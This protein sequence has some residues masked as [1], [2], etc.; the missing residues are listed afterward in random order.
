MI[1]YQYINIV[2]ITKEKGRQIKVKKIFSQIYALKGMILKM[3]NEKA[4]TLIALVITIIVLLIL[5]AISVVALIGDNG[6]LSNSR[7]AKEEHQIS[8]Y[9]EE[10]NLVITEEITERKIEAKQELM[11]KSLDTKIRK[12]EWVNEIYKLDNNKQEQQTFETST[13]LLVESKE[14]YEF[15]IEVNDLKNTAKIISEGKGTG[16]KYKITFNPNG[17]LGTENSQE[18]KQKLSVTLGECTFTKENY[19]F[20]GW[21]E[22]S[23]GTGERYLPQAL[24][25]PSQDVTLYAIWELNVATITFNNN[26]GTGNM[27]SVTVEKEKDS[28]LPVNTF[29]R[30]DYKFIEWNTKPDGTGEKYADKANIN[31]STDIIL[32]AIWQE[33]PFEPETLSIGSA[34]NANKYGWKVTNYEPNIGTVG[35]WRLFYQDE[36]FT[37]IISDNVLSHNINS[38][39][40]KYQSAADISMIGRKLN[41]TLSAYSG[42]Y[43]S[44]RTDISLR[45]AAVLSDPTRTN[46]QNNINEDALFSILSPSIDLYSA[47][48]N[49]VHTT[50]TH[51]CFTLVRKDNY[52]DFSSSSSSSTGSNFTGSKCHGI[53]SAKNSWSWLF[54]SPRDVQCIF[55]ISREGGSWEVL[56]YTSP[57]QAYIKP[58][59]VK[60]IVCFKTKLFNEKYLPHLADE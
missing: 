25:T 33:I 37:Y 32:Y 57:G 6:I 44:S 45:A 34:T 24:Y 10:I 7:K 54:C 55:N 27:A 51:L 43:E 19:K 46:P 52:I 8:Q 21:S 9:R 15:L 18:V 23:D 14:G 26:N 60:P 48:W 30:E 41:P 22:N 36:N 47:S 53:Y 38:S 16:E 1:Q 59:G 35:C 50:S 3:K 5:A 4:I 40:V 28:K 49:A 2:K 31:I 12:K 11:I 58:Q 29:T 20:V 13:H 17:G 39:I 42:I 56:T